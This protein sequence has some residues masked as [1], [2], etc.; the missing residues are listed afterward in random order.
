MVLKGPE[1]VDWAD[2]D[3]GCGRD[4]PHPLSRLICQCFLDAV[5][6]GQAI[7]DAAISGFFK[8]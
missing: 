4:P 6:I 5:W 8:N 2:I 1:K 3:R 7:A